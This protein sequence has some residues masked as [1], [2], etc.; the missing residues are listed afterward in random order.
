MELQ[1]VE[2]NHLWDVLGL[3]RVG[4]N[5][6]GYSVWKMGEVNSSG[7]IRPLGFIVV[8]IHAESQIGTADAGTSQGGQC[9]GYGSEQVLR[10]LSC[11][12]FLSASVVD[13]SITCLWIQTTTCFIYFQ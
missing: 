6:L 4:R 3:V 5:G 12:F 13:L 2:I 9:C 7:V 10:F 1:P 8:Q 11:M